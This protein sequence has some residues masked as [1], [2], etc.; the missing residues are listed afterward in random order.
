MVYVILGKSG[1]HSSIIS[2]QFSS[3]DGFKIIGPSANF[4][5]GYM[6]SAAGDINKDSYGDFQVSSSSASANARSSAGLSYILYGT[7]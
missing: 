1:L 2:S 3:S 4:N 6:I 7:L 5:L